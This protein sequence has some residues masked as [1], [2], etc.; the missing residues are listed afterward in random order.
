M[1][2]QQLH[3]AMREDPQIILVLL[4][5]NDP[6]KYQMIKKLTC[7]Q[8]AV[9]TQV[10]TLACASKNLSVATKVALQMNT[11]IGF[12]PWQANVPLSSLMVVG[13]DTS[14]EGKLTFGAMVAALGLRE[15]P[16]RYFSIAGVRRINPLVCKLK[17]IYFTFVF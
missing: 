8:N 3:D 11:K 2:S 16:G 5:K 15:N 17:L 12:V 4:E 9:P 13:F 1:L 7:V 14:K 6:S 10:I